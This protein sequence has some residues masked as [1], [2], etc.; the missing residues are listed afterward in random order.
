MLQCSTSVLIT[1]EESAIPLPL[2]QVWFKDGHGSGTDKLLL[3]SVAC[4]KRLSGTAHADQVP[5][6]QARRGKTA[7]IEAQS[8]PELHLAAAKRSLRLRPFN[9]YDHRI[10][11]V[12]GP[13]LRFQRR[14]L[15]VLLSC[16]EKRRDVSGS[17]ES[18]T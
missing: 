17:S 13:A 8:V 16:V 12:Q 15:F 11:A 18:G 3:H 1:A 4:Y 10:R 5:E 2:P 14:K 6:E 9:L 7:V